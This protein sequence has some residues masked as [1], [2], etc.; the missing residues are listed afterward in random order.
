MGLMGLMGG[1]IS[2]MSPIGPIRSQRRAR[3]DPTPIRPHAETP[4][5]SY[6]GPLG[7]NSCENA[8]SSHGLAS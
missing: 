5:H 6:L 2:P 3:S 4:A 7:A 1:L 8:C